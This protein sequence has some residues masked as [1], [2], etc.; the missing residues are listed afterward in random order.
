MSTTRSQRRKMHDLPQRFEPLFWNEV[1]GRLSL[2][3]K[4]RRRYE[5]IKRESGSTSI[6]RDLLCQRAAFLSIT[7][8]TLE[9]T[10]TETGQF[11]AGVYVQA[12]NA[13]MGLLQKLGLDSKVKQQ[14]TNLRAYVEEVGT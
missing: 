1:D 11:D 12:S 14:A 5:Q 7:I 2:K 9:C 4:V 8:E 6:Q 3:K 13:L 10:A